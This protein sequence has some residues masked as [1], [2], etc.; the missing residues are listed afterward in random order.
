M[1]ICVCLCGHLYA[2]CGVYSV[3]F[4]SCYPNEGGGTTFQ[5]VEIFDFFSCVSIFFWKTYM[6]ISRRTVGGAK[7]TV[8]PAKKTG[9][10]TKIKTTAKKKK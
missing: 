2:M 10:H 4:M 5:S 9:T 6:C 7:K 8:A 1:S 3:V